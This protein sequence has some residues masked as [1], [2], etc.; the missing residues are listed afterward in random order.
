MDEREIKAII[1]ALLFVWGDPL[2]LNDIS[3]IIE[4]EEEKEKK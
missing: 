4:V 3:K 1:E 2:S